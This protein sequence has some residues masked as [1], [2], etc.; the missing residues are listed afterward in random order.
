[1]AVSVQVTSQDSTTGEIHIFILHGFWFVCEL[2][3]TIVTVVFSSFKS[4]FNTV[5]HLA[6][7]N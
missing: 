3:M 2:L 5:V 7:L 4:I 6:F 1:M